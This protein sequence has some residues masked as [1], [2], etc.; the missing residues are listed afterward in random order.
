M[1]KQQAKQNTTAAEAKPANAE[2]KKEKE[3]KK[4]VPY[5]VPEGKLDNWPDDYDPK[6]HKPLR[7]HHFKDES[8]YW[9]RRADELEDQA[10]KFRQKAEEIKQLGGVRDVKKA[11]RLIKMQKQL[12]ELKK[13]LGDEGADVDAILASVAGPEEKSDE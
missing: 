6:T 2:A 4:L 3:K 8:V 13:A 10:K 7:G 9:L 11:K 12:A 5:P 1:A